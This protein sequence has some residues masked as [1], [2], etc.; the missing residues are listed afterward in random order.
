[1]WQCLK[2]LNVLQAVHDQVE[3]EDWQSCPS[4]ERME[5]SSGPRP[6]SLASIHR[7]DHCEVPT[8]AQHRR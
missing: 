1:M 7:V 4:E 2:E 5:V 6:I 3:S 8:K